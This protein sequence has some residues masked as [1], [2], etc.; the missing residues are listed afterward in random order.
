MMTE[1]TTSALDLFSKPALQTSIVKGSWVEV[2][3]TNALDDGGAI[4]FEIS[5]SGTDYLDLANTFIKAKVRVISANGVAYDNDDMVAP[6]NN[7][8]HSMFNKVDVTLNGKPCV[9]AII[10]TH[11]GPMLKHF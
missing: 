4:D 11:T 6:V 5:G 2:R 1:V 7:L 9:L 8:L 3:P 10:I